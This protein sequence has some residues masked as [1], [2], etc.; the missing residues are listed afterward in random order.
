ML[1]A[2]DNAT[3][4]TVASRYLRLQVA[5]RANAVGI[6]GCAQLLAQ[7][8]PRFFP[9]ASTQLVYMTAYVHETHRTNSGYPSVK[10]P[11][12]GVTSYPG[13]S[14]CDRTEQQDYNTAQPHLHTGGN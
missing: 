9:L 2:T 11:T 8:L 4:K 12:V 3:Q 6:V 7:H 14:D 5:I 10:S 13:P 1:C